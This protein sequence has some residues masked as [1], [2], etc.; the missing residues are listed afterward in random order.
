MT[1]HATQ[2]WIYRPQARSDPDAPSGAAQHPP[3]PD[4]T[5]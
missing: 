1:H 4:T 3:P 2:L 5:H